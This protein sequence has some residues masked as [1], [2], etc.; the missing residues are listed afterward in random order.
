MANTKRD[1]NREGEVPPATGS[2]PGEHA[3]EDSNAGQAFDDVIERRITSP[4]PDE[5]EEALL[6]EAIE[7]SFPASDPIAI[8]TPEEVKERKRPGQ[9][10]TGGTGGGESKH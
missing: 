5:R 7:E 8:S 6:D 9:G 3:P 1:S 2:P 4:D 10:K